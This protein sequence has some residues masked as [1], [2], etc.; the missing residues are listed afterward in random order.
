MIA[1]PYDMIAYSPAVST[2]AIPTAIRFSA[3]N[4]SGESYE[5]APALLHARHREGGVPGFRQLLRPDDP[6]R[7]AGRVLHHH[8]RRDDLPVRGEP[9]DAAGQQRVP[10]HE[11]REDVAHGR[12]VEALRLPDRLEEHPR[13]VVGE[14][15]EP[16][17]NLVVLPHVLLGEQLRGRVLERGGPPHRGDQV[18][19]AG[20]ERLPA[21]LVRPPTT[22]GDELVADA[23]LEILAVHRDEGPQV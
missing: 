14:R 9:Y 18:V 1:R 16:I 4:T 23:K 15:L 20:P 19:R 12:P 11:L 10:H 22:V 13:G 7:V 21:F 17:G 5:G 8:V 3:E 2:A 6:D